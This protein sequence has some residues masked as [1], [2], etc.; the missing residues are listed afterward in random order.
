MYLNADFV[1]VGARARSGVALV[2]TLAAVGDLKER[3]SS[4]RLKVEPGG[5]SLN[6]V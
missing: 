5:F 2:R 6:E 4:R 1:G 3:K